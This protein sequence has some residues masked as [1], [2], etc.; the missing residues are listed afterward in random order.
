MQGWRAVIADADG[1]LWA[2]AA[3]GS[4]VVQCDGEGRILE[5]HEVSAPIVA[6]APSSAGTAAFALDRGGAVRELGSAADP[7]IV[8]GTCL[9]V[10]HPG[11]RVF[12]GGVAGVA[13]LAGGAPLWQR[14]AAVVAICLGAD[15]RRLYV[16]DGSELTELDASTGAARIVAHLPGRTVISLALAPGGL[17]GVDP[18]RRAV[19]GI[20]LRHGTSTTIFTGDWAD[21]A[22][23]TYLRSRDVY[24]LADASAPVLTLVSR[25]GSTARPLPL[26]Y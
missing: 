16:V 4:H 14:P 5:R 24:L 18:G 6:L 15:R 19:I 7:V 22:G 20:N 23:V 1:H 10:D 26:R 8:S 13:A 3:D 11:G 2:A 25:D 17:V 9:A 12:A 21:P